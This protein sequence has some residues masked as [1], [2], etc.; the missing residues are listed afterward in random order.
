[1]ENNKYYHS[2]T[3]DRDRCRGCI[4]CIKRC[5]TEA[6]RVRNSKAKIIKERCIDCGECI[7]VC[8]HFA[9][10][11]VTDDFHMIEDYEYKVAMPAPTLY[12]Q[13]KGVTDVNIVLTGLLE[14]GFD[15]VYE[16]AKAAEL[17]TLATREYMD[18]N[19]TVRPLINSACPAVVRLI[20][21]RFPSLID[22]I[23]PI[24]APVELA[25]ILARHEAVKETGLPPEK[26]G[27]FFI[28]PCAAKVTN[29]KNPIGFHNKLIDG[30][31]SMSEIHKRLIPVIKKIK[32]PKKLSVVYNR[33]V[34]WASSGGESLGLKTPKYVAVDGINNVIQ[35]LEDLEDEKLEDIEFIEALAC[36]GG[37]VGGP[38]TVENNFVSKKRV[39]DIANSRDE[40]E[41]GFHIDYNDIL[42]DGEVEYD[43]ILNL[44]PEV[45]V[46]IEKMQEMN[47]IL[48]NL[49][50]LD[51]GSCGAPSCKALAEDIVRGFGSE[52]DCI[53]T[54][55]ERVKIL[56]KEMIELEEHMP[57][58][59]RSEEK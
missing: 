42:W 56:A 37:C 12:G 23:L 47:R 28:T 13:F 5:P 35:L 3:L 25:A 20:K 49:P 19:K 26:I 8:P 43:P 31:L 53:F 7:R 9:K 6:I 14:I 10:K 30:A 17:V 24:L 18:K 34:N 2:V 1:M 38:L 22:N 15:K 59:F 51:C 57:P 16:V 46:A 50:G 52:Q 58:P 55:R 39:R 41:W 33:G 4:N 40:K 32:E 44:D 54:M 27:I 21:V 45:E 36:T 11:V 48:K 29:I